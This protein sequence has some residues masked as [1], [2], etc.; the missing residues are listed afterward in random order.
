M[1][2]CSICLD[3]IHPEDKVAINL[4]VV[5]KRIHKFHDTC[6]ELDLLP[7]CII[8]A[9]ILTLVILVSGPFALITHSPQVRNRANGL[10]FGDSLK[11]NKFTSKQFCNLFIYSSHTISVPD[12][13]YSRN[14]CALNQILRFH[15]YHLV[16][17]S[18]GELYSSPMLSSTQ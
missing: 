18:G 3:E 1:D 14:L 8:R 10:L 2:P 4:N 15:C 16:D 9:S 7:S 6:I 12:V 17:T 5:G 13:G 11:I